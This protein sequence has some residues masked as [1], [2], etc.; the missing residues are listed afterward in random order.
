MRRRK[1]KSF[2]L[3]DMTW[4]YK[5]LRVMGVYRALRAKCQVRDCHLEQKLSSDVQDEKNNEFVFSKG[6]K[7]WQTHRTKSI[8]YSQD[9]VQNANARPLAQEVSRISR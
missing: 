2:R 4:S 6:H 7:L 1:L 8:H 3:A 5:R 9:P